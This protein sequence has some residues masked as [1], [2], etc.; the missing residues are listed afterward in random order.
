MTI[1]VGIFWRFEKVEEEIK[2]IEKYAIFIDGRIYNF[3]SYTELLKSINLMNIV[4]DSLEVYKLDK[5]L[6][7]KTVTTTEWS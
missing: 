1:M 6:L 2:L 7:P 3:Y 4:I 5:V